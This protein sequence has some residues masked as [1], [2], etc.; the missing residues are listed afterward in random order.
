MGNRRKVTSKVHVS[1][2]PRGRYSFAQ[3]HTLLVYWQR[4]ILSDPSASPLERAAALELAVVI[5]E[6]QGDMVE[7]LIVASEVY[8]VVDRWMRAA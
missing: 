3:R 4:R 8:A 1:Q 5:A 7:A 2:S 6:D